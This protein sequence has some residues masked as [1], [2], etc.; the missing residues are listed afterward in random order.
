MRKWILGKKYSYY[1][2]E[3]LLYQILVSYLGL[4]DS[5]GM[6]P[7]STSGK[8]NEKRLVPHIQTL[9]GK[10]CAPTT[11]DLRRLIYQFAEQLHTKHR[12]DKRQKKLVVNRCY[13]FK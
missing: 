12:F 11:A 4:S 7:Q 1:S 3:Q 9:Q 10:G 5:L 13:C 8:E 2:S 6:G